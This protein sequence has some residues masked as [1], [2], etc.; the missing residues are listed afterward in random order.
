MTRVLRWWRG[1][2][3]P[4]R[5]RVYS[6]GALQ[7][8]ILSLVAALVV[9]APSLLVATVAILSG[10]VTV[11][12]VEAYPG[13]SGWPS[14][15]RHRRW[16]R[17]GAT[18][19]LLAL[20]VYCVVDSRTAA[21]TDESAQGLVAG[22][23]VVMLWVLAIGSSLRHRWPA[24]AAASAVTAVAFTGL[25][26]DALKYGLILFVVGAFVDTTV[27]LTLW[28]LNVVDELEAA[29]EVE[30][31]LRVAE[32]RVRF[33]RD[34]HDVVGRG[35][36]AIAVKSELA[37]TLVNAGATERAAT[38]MNEVKALAVESMGQMRALVR[39]YRDIDLESEI[40]GARSLLAAAGCVLDVAG[41]PELVPAELHQAAAWIVREGTTNIVK[42]STATNAT[43]SLGGAGL[44]LTNN[45]VSAVQRAQGAGLAGL[46]ERL[47][48]VGATLTTETTSDGFTLVARWENT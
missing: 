24:L 47:A 15:T 1:L 32:E 46:T 8:S 37:A 27:R 4:T 23:L 7:I 5:F 6:R 14:D 18:A 39:G 48:A 33:A 41:A 38:E 44:A 31:R 43:L 30:A 34:L 26:S 28:T 13:L 25:D 21:S 45:G 9:A 29:K 40:A 36:S 22:G 2:S 20:W 16:I 3:G 12:A 10:I 11:V 35:F 17:V 19:V 42:H